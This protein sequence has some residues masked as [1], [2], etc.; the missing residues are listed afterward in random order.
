MVIVLAVWVWVWVR[1]S[2]CVYVCVWKRVTCQMSL[3]WFV[4]PLSICKHTRT[5]TQTHT[6]THVAHTHTDTSREQ[7]MPTNWRRAPKSMPRFCLICCAA[8]HLPRFLPPPAPLPLLLLLMQLVYNEFSLRNWKDLK[9]AQPRYKNGYTQEQED[10]KE[11]EGK[12]ER[13]RAGM[14]GSLGQQITRKWRK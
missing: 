5:H 1:V 13:E 2:P 6:Y 12:A 11:R 14:C 10:G 3:T 7:L 4:L 8:R 9:L